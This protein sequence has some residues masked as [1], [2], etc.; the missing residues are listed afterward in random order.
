VDEWV[1]GDTLPTR[2]VNSHSSTRRRIRGLA[3]RPGDE[4]RLEGVASCP[5]QNTTEMPLSEQ[6]CR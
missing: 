3:L 6:Y 2:G 1:A 5:K 4:I